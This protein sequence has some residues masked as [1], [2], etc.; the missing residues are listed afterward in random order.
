MAKKLTL[1]AQRE[2]LNTRRV[3]NPHNLCAAFNPACKS[4]YIDYRAQDTG[5]AGVGA[6]WSV[7]GLGFQ[8]EPNGPWYEHGSRSFGVLGREDKARCLE[9]AKNWATEAGYGDAWAKDPFGAWQTEDTM[10]AV[11]KWIAEQQ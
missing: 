5:R 2:L 4:V 9:E 7:F 1:K 11:N 3:H 6:A 10:V 8:T